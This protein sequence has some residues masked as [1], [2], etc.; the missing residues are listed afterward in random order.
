MLN[1]GA[2]PKTQFA[3][4]A[5]DQRCILGGDLAVEA[6]GRGRSSVMAGILLRA[7]SIPPRSGTVVLE[8]ED[9]TAGI[10]LPLADVAAVDC[11][12]ATSRCLQAGVD[13]RR[14]AHASCY[15]GLP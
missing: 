1:S 12:S 11:P 4:Q 7:Q 6:L 10:V 5:V 15:A 3:G 14:L 2:H 8:D 13:S 9:G